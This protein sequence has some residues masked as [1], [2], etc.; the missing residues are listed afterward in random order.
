MSGVAHARNLIG[1]V[2][3]STYRMRITGVHHLPVRGG[4]LLVGEQNGLLDATILASGLT[5]PVRV[6][7]Q[8]AGTTPRWSRLTSVLG[9]IDVDSHASVWPALQEGVATLS[10]GGA[11]AAFISSSLAAV[12]VAPPA[13]VAAY[14]H[15]RSGV[16]IVPVTMFDTA[17]PRPSDIPRPRSTIECHI[18]APC[19]VPTPQDRFHVAAL[20]QHAERIRQVCADADEI[21][22]DRTGR[23]LGRAEPH[24]GQRD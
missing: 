8:N 2:L 11:V 20:R 21:A 4:V 18:G 23:T 13:A 7:A 16:P 22:A 10:R 9:R 1:P 17:G 19:V 12:A 3:A 5:R 6:F 14:L 15:A 24:N